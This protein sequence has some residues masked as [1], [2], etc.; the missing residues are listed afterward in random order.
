MNKFILSIMM[1]LAVT[2]YVHAVS[3]SMG[4]SVAEGRG[5]KVKTKKVI[6]N[7]K[8]DESIKNKKGEV[9]QS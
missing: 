6:N 9:K 4:D 5:A 2:G 8:N 7:A 1:S 3:V